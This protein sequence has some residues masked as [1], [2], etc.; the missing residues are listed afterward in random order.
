MRDELRI[1]CGAAVEVVFNDLVEPTG[2][3]KTV[4]VENRVFSDDAIGSAPIGMALP[5]MATMVPTNSASRCQALA[6][7]PS[8]TGMTNQISRP[9]ATA[10]AAGSGLKPISSPRVTNPAC[11][12]K[13]TT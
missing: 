1:E 6:V 13:R 9:I 12:V 7:T 4:Q 2:D 3:D 5:M 10:T 11:G 8:G